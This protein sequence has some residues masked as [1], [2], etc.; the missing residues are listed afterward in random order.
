MARSSKKIVARPGT[1]R[2][3][4]QVQFSTRLKI[5]D[6][7]MV[8]VGG[9]TKKQRVYQG[10]VGKVLGFIPK[11]NRVIVEG[12]KVIKRHKRAMTNAEAAGI[13]QKDGSFHISNVMYYSEDLKRPVRLSVKTLENGKRVRGFID[14]KKKSFQQIEA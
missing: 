14:P 8:L 9:N 6:T 12:V 11:R 10:K 1:S 13:I 3:G 7:V 2:K 4:R 5:G